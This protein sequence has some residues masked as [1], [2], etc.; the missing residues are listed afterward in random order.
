[1]NSIASLVIS[2]AAGILCVA[3]KHPAAANDRIK[4][5]SAHTEA[6]GRY[7]VDSKGMALYVFSEDR[8]GE[9]SSAPVSNCKGTCLHVWKLVETTGA[10]EPGSDVEIGRA[11]ILRSNGDTFATFNG[12]P[13]YRY[14][15]DIMPGDIK[16]QGVGGFGGEWRL[17]APTGNPVADR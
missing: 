11:G 8:R 17:V 3:V 16:G 7:L 13:L 10:P 2:I 1:M 4:I 12:W 9:S 5:L 14:I 15:V 6:Y